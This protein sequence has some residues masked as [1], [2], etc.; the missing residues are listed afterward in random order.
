MLFPELEEHECGAVQIEATSREAQPEFDGIAEQLRRTVPAFDDQKLSLRVA[1]RAQHPAA[2][3]R[4]ILWVTCWLIGCSV[5]L[6]QDCALSCMFF[7]AM[8][9]A[10]QV[11]R[12]F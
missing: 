9:R 7:P 11:R 8:S 2:V 5:G 6:E 12:S 3:R 4:G 1:R 10:V